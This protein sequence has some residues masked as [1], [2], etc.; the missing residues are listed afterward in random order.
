MVYHFY[1]VHILVFISRIVIVKDEPFTVIILDFIEKDQILNLYAKFLK[2]KCHLEP[3]PEVVPLAVNKR[4]ESRF[5]H[6]SHQV[7][8]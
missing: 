8:I 2:D 4:N 6:V 5:H 3:E 1:D 7:G